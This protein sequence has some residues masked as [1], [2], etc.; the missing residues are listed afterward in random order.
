M[1]R[2]IGAPHTRLTLNLG[3]R[4]DIITPVKDAHGQ[5]S[6]FNPATLSL[7]IP[8]VNGGSDT[9]GINTDY[10]SIAPRFGFSYTP[11]RQHSGSR[12]VWAGLLPG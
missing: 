6:N 10:R 8:G 7:I 11:R 12:R 5:I 4:Y 9:A 3:L 1:C 2:M